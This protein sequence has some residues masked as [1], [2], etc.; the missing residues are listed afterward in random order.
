MGDV[1]AGWIIGQDCCRVLRQL[2][3]VVS[4]AWQHRARAACLR[5][6]NRNGRRSSAVETSRSSVPVHG[7]EACLDHPDGECDVR[8][9]TKIARHSTESHMDITLTDRQ[10]DTAATSKL[11]DR[12]GGRRGVGDVR[13]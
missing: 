4:G 9:I 6:A 7:L 1:T 2:V 5:I 3:G 13:R 10:P 8:G 11:L 12:R